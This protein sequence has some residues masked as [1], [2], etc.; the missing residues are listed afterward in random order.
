MERFKAHS[1]HTAYET[2]NPPSKLSNTSLRFVCISDNHGTTMPVPDG[3]VLLH[4]GDLTELGRLAEMERVMK[5]L[6]A[7]PHPVKI[8]IGGNHDVGP[9]FHDKIFQ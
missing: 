9:Q 6:C 5:W 1:I 2:D 3:D 4:A 7:L 8:I